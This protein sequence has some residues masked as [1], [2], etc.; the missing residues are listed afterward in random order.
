MAAYEIIDWDW[1]L[2]SCLLLTSANP[3]YRSKRPV[4]GE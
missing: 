2:G 3:T 4:L 1:S